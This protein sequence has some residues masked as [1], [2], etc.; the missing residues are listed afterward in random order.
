[1]VDK[2]RSGLAARLGRN[3]MLGRKALGLTQEQMATELKVEPETISRFERGAT[4]PS[5]PTLERIA[6]ILGTTMGELLEE[7]EPRQFTEA[8]QLAVLLRP[9]SDSDRAHAREI[10]E[11]LSTHL[12]KRKTPKRKRIKK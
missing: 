5:I 11:K 6:D 9:L 12:T 8:E 3:I 4:L 10:L 2:H 1:M 7:G